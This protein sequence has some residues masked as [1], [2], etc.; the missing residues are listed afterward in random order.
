KELLRSFHERDTVAVE[1][2]SS[3]SSYS[4]GANLKLADAQHVIA[5]EY[6]FSSWPRLKQQVEALSRA[7][8]PA[9]QLSAAVCASDAEKTSRVLESH[10]ELKAGLNEPMPNYGEMQAVLAAGQR[11]DRKTIDVLV[12]AGADINARN[13]HWSGSTGVLDDCAPDMAAFLIEHGAVLDAHAAARLGMLDRLQEFVS[14]DSGS[15]NARGWN[16][17]TPLHLASTVEIAQYLL[18]QGADID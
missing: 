13:D 5:R 16:G 8:S 3:L 1:R 6:G 17:H 2:F 4:E 18:E 9:E 12:R 15:V 14:A 7:L 10:P 11:S